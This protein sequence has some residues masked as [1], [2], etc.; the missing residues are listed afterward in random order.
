MKQ[1][2]LTLTITL[3]AALVIAGCAGTRGTA[4]RT[5][6]A[7]PIYTG[8]PAGVI[9]SGTDLVLRTNESISTDRAVEGT[10]YSA[11]VARSIVDASGNTIVP[12]GSPAQLMV[13]QSSGGGTVGTPNL[14]LALNSIT[15]GG[16][17]YD[18][19]T[20]AQE[21]RSGNEGLG[22]NR[23][24]A[25]M[26]GGGALLGTVIGAIA[27]GGTGAAIGAAA[28]AAGGA[29]V[30]VITRGDRIRVPAETLLTFRLDHPIRLRGYR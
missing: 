30:Q 2:Y 20:E 21:V 9:P 25:E 12:L 17:K 10:M 24:T 6:P 28:G 3:S 16:R 5:A 14:E 22:A 19:V 13:V 27:G 4:S 11:E 15:V 1:T 26:V 7:G 29:A 23:R 18:V 8:A